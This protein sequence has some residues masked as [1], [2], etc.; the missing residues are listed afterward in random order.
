MNL[1]NDCLIHRIIVNNIR[2][3]KMVVYTINGC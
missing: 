1:L 3:E 2:D